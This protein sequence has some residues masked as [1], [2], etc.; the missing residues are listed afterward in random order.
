MVVF[1]IKIQQN[2]HLYATT[3]KMYS[4]KKGYSFNKKIHIYNKNIYVCNDSIYMDNKTLPCATKI[5]VRQYIQRYI[6]TYAVVMR[7]IC[8]CAIYIVNAKKYV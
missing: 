7:P 4:I 1:G 5:Y 6:C 2:S 8:W 3:K